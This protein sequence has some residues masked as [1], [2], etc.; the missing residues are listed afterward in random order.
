[1]MA[2]IFF[3]RPL[4]PAAWNLVADAC[5]SLVVARCDG[6]VPPPGFPPVSK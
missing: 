5:A 2:S 1:M 6:W 3:I 4:A